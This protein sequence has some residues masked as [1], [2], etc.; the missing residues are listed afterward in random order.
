MAESGAR[1][2]FEP[3]ARAVQQV[4]AGV[5]EDQLGDPT[6]CAQWTVGDLIDHLMGLTEAFRIAA[7]KA[8][9]PASAGPPPG[10]S[11]N[12]LDPQWRRLLPA[13]LDDLVAAWRSPA[14]WT[15]ETEAGGVVLPAAVMGLVALNEV[16]VHGWDLAASTGQPY[17]LDSA[18]AEAVHSLVAQQA[19]AEGTPGFFG[20]SITVPVDAPLLD[21]VIGL[22]GRDPKWTS[23]AAAT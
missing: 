10:P 13:R 12:H 18:T 23:P 11:K 20:P 3:A 14:A 8:A 16:V 19:S 21:R 2:D 6:P 15:G 5:R 22:T 9:D 4:A 7:E 1:P 17:E